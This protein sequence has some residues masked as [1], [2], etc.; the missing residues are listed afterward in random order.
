MPE[1]EEMPEVKPHKV[2]DVINIK[3]QNYAAGSEVML[4]D[5]EYEA[6]KAA[7]VPFEGDEPKTEEE[8][9]SAHEEG[10]KAL[11]TEFESRAKASAEKEAR[12]EAHE[13]GEEF[14]EAKFSEE[15]DRQQKV[16]NPEYEAPAPRE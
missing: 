5:E 3:G 7:G 2:R 11:K 10:A 4:T 15:Y 14:D 9:Q 12:D 16:A 8:I 6:V 13:K 1:T